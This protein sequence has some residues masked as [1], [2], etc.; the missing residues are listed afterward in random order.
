MENHHTKKTFIFAQL[1]CVVACGDSTTGISGQGTYSYYTKGQTHKKAQSS[2]HRMMLFRDLS[3]NGEVFY[4]IE[5]RF[6][7]KKLM[8]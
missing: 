7:N 8:E 6:Q 3:G 1:L 2:Y 5:D 4:L